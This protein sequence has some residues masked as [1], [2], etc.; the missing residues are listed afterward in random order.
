MTDDVC[1]CV[2][3]Y[4]DDLTS[5]ETCQ[6]CDLSCVSCVNGVSCVTCDPVKKR[7]LNASAFYDG[8]VSSLCVCEYGLYSPGSGLTCLP[9]HYSCEVCSG[10]NL[11]NC[12]FCDSG[13]HRILSGTRCRCRNGY[14]DDG[15][16]EICLS[17]HT[18]CPTCF[19]AAIDQCNSCINTKFFMSNQ[20]K[21]YDTC[22]DYSF[23]NLTGMICSSCD[24]NCLHCLS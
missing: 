19:G 23:D 12:L 15:S 13:A 8:S 24:S 11:N 1:H 4:F 7:L 21:C 10:P 6:R 3:G 22:P 14:Y 2:V 17:C 16:L 9:C 5:N 18:N 20:T